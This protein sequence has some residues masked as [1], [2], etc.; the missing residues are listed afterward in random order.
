[1]HGLGSS[2]GAGERSRSS[3]TMKVV[4]GGWSDAG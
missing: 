3:S 4:L 2:V 1:M